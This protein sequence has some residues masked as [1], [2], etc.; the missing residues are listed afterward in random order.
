MLNFLFF[1]H[2]NK[3]QDRE[4]GARSVRPAEIE[5]RVGWDDAAQRAGSG[6]QVIGPP[7]CMRLWPVSL[8][9]RRSRA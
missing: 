4:A 2:T 9:W 1:V 5:K 3:K 6:A 7:Q 8:R